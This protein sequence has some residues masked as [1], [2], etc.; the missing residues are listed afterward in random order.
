M[1]SPLSN[2]YTLILILLIVHFIIIKELISQLYQLGILLHLV[3]YNHSS[4]LINMTN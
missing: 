1:I 3:F 2:W 4:Y